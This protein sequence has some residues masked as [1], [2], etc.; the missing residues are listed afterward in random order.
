MRKLRAFFHRFAELWRKGR[1]DLEFQE[2]L[3][4][5]VE[6]ESEAGI[7]AGMNPQEARRAAL[8]RLN[9]ESTKEQYRVQRG[10]PRLESWLQDLR[11]GLR[12]LRKNPGF[13]LLGLLTIAIGIGAN[14]VMFSAVNAVLLHGVPFHDPSRLVMIWEKHPAVKGFLAER[15]PVRTQSYLLWKDQSRSFEGMGAALFSAV[16]VSG[17]EK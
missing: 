5:L 13:A 2:E 3:S 16:N 14:T 9:P 6:M 12:M 4:N 15:L 7:A 1:R 17:F 8:M 10:L 11:F